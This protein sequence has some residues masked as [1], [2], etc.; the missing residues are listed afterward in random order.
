MRSL[1]VD[2]LRK[3]AIALTSLLFTLSCGVL[4]PSATPENQ[5]PQSQPQQILSPTNVAFTQ[6]T[7]LSLDDL[8]AIPPKDIIQEIGF[9]GGLGGG[10][11]QCQQEYQSPTFPGVATRTYEWMDE[12][13]ITICGLV[14][15]EE[16]RVIAKLPNDT[17]EDSLVA[18]QTEFVGNAEITYDFLPVVNSPVGEYVFTF[19]GNTW[20]LEYIAVVVEPPD[21]RLYLH[22]SQLFLVNFPPNE[23]VRV[24]VYGNDSRAIGRSLIGWK[25]YKVN[26]GEIGRAHV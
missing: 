18:R 12:V 9:Y 4:A 5:K 25:E 6:D 1:E 22:E 26:D 23:S 19:I 2:V 16:V 10:G 13:S 21:A 8:D 20:T 17:F 3:Y 7:S 15:G 11:S 14:V 24:L